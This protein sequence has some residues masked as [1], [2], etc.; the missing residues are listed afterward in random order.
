M[1]TRE[2][3]KIEIYAFM[4]GVYVALY[5]DKEDLITY[6]QSDYEAKKA[7]VLLITNAHYSGRFGYKEALAQVFTELNK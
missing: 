5:P 1:E 6:S 3:K 7:N 2:V 4:E